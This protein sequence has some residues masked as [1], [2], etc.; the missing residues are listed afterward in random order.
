MDRKVYALAAGGDIPCSRATGKIL[1]PRAAVHAWLARHGSTASGATPLTIARPTVIVGS[2]DPLLDWALRESRSGIAS[3]FDGSLD[4][5]E[6]FARADAVAAGIHLFEAGDGA[7]WNVRNVSDAVGNEPVVLVEWAWRARGLIVAAGNPL[8]IEGVATLPGRR[9]KLRQPE[10]ASQVLFL[11]LLAREGVSTQNLAPV[12]PPARNETDLALA[13]ADGKADAAFG[14]S[15]AARPYRLGFVPIM[16]ERYD[17]LVWRRFWFEEPFQRFLAF[18]RSPDF[19]AHAADLG[20]YDIG[21][22]G[23]VHFNGA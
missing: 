4:G 21:G 7:G 5:M 23:T 2:H 9:V 10:A 16:R 18:C 17:L 13:V 20:G 6:R 15:C 22:F 8:G 12:A 1:F 19:A 14:L 3:F 11:Q